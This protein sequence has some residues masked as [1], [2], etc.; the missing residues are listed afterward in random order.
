MTETSRHEAETPSDNAR[1]NESRGKGG[2]ERRGRLPDWFRVSLGGADSRNRLR[3]LLDDL[4]LR[5]VCQSALCPNLYQ[6][7]ERGTATFMILGDRCTRDCRFCA[8]QN[9]PPAPPEADEPERIAVAV[10]RLGLR[11]VVIT[12][13]TRDDLPDGGSGQFAATVASIRSETAA[14]GIEILIPDFGGRH[15]PL[16]VVIDAQPT[17]LNHNLETSE[18]LT[19]TLRSGADYRRSLEV[20]KRS[21]DWGKPRGIAVKSGFMLGLGESEKEVAKMLSDLRENGVDCVTIGQYLSPSREHWPVAR[22]VS[23]DEFEQWEQRARE[24]FG[25]AFAV[26]G[27]HV[28]SSYMAE[29]AMEAVSSKKDGCIP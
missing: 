4:G 7:W 16:R 26:S 15:D 18:R 21:A 19:P 12:S 5:T 24:D 20:L 3:R 27:P 8:V 23:P 9:G 28:R 17:V 29:K 1:P 22:Y 10:N 13:V 2:A 6:C 25:F 11:Y 14:A